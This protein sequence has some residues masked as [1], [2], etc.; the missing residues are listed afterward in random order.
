MAAATGSIVANV[1]D[2][3]RAHITLTV[4]YIIWGAGLPLAMLVMVLYYQRLVLYKLP[5]REVIVSVFLPLGPLGQGS[6]A[7]QNL[8]KVALKT[9]FISARGGEIFYY[10]GIF[11]GLIMWGYATI[12]LIFAIAAVAARTSSKIPF[13]LGWWGFTFPIGVF[14]VATTSLAQNLPSK[15]FRVLATVLSI[16]ETLLWIIVSVFTLWK[17]AKGEL[18]FAPCLDQ[19]FERLAKEERKQRRSCRARAV[20]STQQGRRMSRSA[21]HST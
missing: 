4:S 19:S 3:S 9:S 7:I 14:T 20:C 6:F 1:L 13:N 18:F 17:V 8:G 16:A 21:L 10:A 12:W 11:V 15:F 2:D 5:P